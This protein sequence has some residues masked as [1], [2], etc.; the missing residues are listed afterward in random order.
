VL[1]ISIHLIQNPQLLATIPQYAKIL[2]GPGKDKIGVNEQ[3]M[4]L[5][6]KELRNILLLFLFLA[7]NGFSPGGSGT[8]VRHDTQITHITQNNT[9]IKRNTAHKTTHTINTLHRMK[10]QQS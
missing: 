1:N 10:I 6:K 7:A 9:T 3:F 5:H 4:L 2:F 8:P